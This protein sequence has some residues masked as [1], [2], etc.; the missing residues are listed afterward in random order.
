MNSGRALRNALKINR[1]Y[2]EHS[3]VFQDKP[4]N[5]KFDIEWITAQAILSNMKVETEKL[6]RETGQ[7]GNLMIPF[8][9][10][11][12]NLKVAGRDPL[13]AH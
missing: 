3:D 4:N 10:A 2:Y 1:I 6:R 8:S 5:P 9:P 12:R 11:I 13:F 7:L